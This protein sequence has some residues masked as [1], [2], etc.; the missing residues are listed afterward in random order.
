MIRTTLLLSFLVF[1]AQTVSAAPKQ[2]C[3]SLDSCIK[4]VGKL[5]D[6]SYLYTAKLKGKVS[7]TSGFKLT[8]ENADSFLSKVLNLNGYTRIPLTESEGYLIVNARDIRYTPTPLIS[9]NKEAAPDLPDSYDYYQMVYT[10]KDADPV[11]LHEFTRS[12][13]PFLSRYG[14]VIAPKSE[15]PLIIQDTA[16]NLKRVYKILVQYDRKLSKD[17]REKREQWRNRDYEIKKL[18]AQNCASQKEVIKEYLK[19]K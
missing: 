1:S 14:R 6:K 18:Q 15:G 5:T 10:A 9:A 8:K 4:V 13:R 3:Q 2:V 7:M 19:K 16:A 12:I 17:E 11:Q